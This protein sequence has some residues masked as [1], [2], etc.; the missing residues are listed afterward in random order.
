MKGILGIEKTQMTADDSI[1]AVMDIRSA[2]EV[3]CTTT[4][5][6]NSFIEKILVYDP[7][8]DDPGKSK[9]PL[10]SRHLRIYYLKMTFWLA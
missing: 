9:L 10:F 6:R 4:N 5:G 3:L 7:T 2:W 8:D 1:R